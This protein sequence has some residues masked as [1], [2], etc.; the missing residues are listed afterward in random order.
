MG[1]EGRLQRVQPAIGPQSF[2]GGDRGAVLHDGKRQARHHPAPVDEHSAGTA[3][4]M[5]AALLSTGEIEIF[6]E[7]V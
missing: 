1:D 2:D 4:A 3:L 6:A 5:V 7:R